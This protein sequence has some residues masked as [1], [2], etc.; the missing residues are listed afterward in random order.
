MQKT[1]S[2]LFARLQAA[3]KGASASQWVA[4]IIVI[5]A[6]IML[7]YVM[8]DRNQSPRM[9]EFYVAPDES[10]NCNEARVGMSEGNLDCNKSS[11]FIKCNKMTFNE[12]A[13]FDKDLTILQ[14]DGANQHKF[15]MEFLNFCNNPECSSTRSLQDVVNEYKYHHI[16]S[17]LHKVYTNREP[18]EKEFEVL[19]ENR[20]KINQYTKKLKNKNDQLEKRIQSYETNIIDKL[21]NEKNNLQAYL[22]EE[23]AE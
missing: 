1:M 23:T 9:T 6:I 17:Q 5:G 18:I 20:F 22:P 21:V 12:R 4:Y 11:P 13:D 15:G 19:M 7:L 10:T 8:V 3:F 16:P 2:H 14:P